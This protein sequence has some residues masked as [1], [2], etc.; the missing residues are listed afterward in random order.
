MVISTL[1][2]ES[3]DVREQLSPQA[4]ALVEGEYL[5]IAAADQESFLPR[6]LSAWIAEVRRPV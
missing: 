2:A 5:H 6:G 1:R 3:L 4:R